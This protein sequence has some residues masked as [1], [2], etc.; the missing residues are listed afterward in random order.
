M[1]RDLWCDW[2]IE[3]RKEFGSVGTD[4]LK[5]LRALSSY[6]LKNG[7]QSGRIFLYQLAELVEL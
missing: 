7:F 5:K 6:L 1:P 2:L 4:R 3:H